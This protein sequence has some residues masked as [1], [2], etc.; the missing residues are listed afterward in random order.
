[1]EWRGDRGAKRLALYGVSLALALILSYVEYLL[2][3]HFAVPGIKLGLSNAVGLFLLYRLRFRD[4]AAVSLMRVVLSGILFG[5]V[6]TMAYGAAG[7][8]LSLVCMTLAKRF[9][10]LRCTGVS[11]IGGVMH[12][13]GQLMVAALLMETGKLVYYLP[14]LCVSGTVAGVLI[15]VITGLLLKKVPSLPWSE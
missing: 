3:L 13:A 12:N 11:V 10:S 6:V 1:M 15:G 2:P 7:A 14:V 8:A 5:S 9:S 4:A